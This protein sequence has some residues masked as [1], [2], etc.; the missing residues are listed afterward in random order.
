MKRSKIII[1]GS[2]IFA[3]VAVSIFSVSHAAQKQPPPTAA[4]SQATGK[5]SQAAPALPDLIVEGVWLDKEGFINFQLKNAGQAEIPDAQHRQ[6]MVRVTYGKEHKDFS[7]RKTLKKRPPVDPTGLLKKPGEVVQY[8]TQIRVKERL[9]VTVM[10][11][12]TKRI[13]EANEQN[14]QD[15]S[16]GLT[17]KTAKEMKPAPPPEVRREITQGEGLRPL[18]DEG[19]GRG[20]EEPDLAIIA[21]HIRTYTGAYS[22]TA[23]Y[24][25]NG[26][27]DHE[28]IIFRVF[29]K[30]NGPVMFT[31]FISVV[32][33][34]GS[35]RVTGNKYVT[36]EPAGP[37]SS[38]EVL[39]TLNQPTMIEHE[40]LSPGTYQFK[41]KF[42][43]SMPSDPVWENNYSPNEVTL[44]LRSLPVGSAIPVETITLPSHG[45]LTGSVSNRGN[46]TNSFIQVGN[47]GTGTARGFISF[48][49]SAIQRE[50]LRRGRRWTEFEITS[51]TLEIE[52]YQILAF[53]PHEGGDDGWG[54]YHA[55]SP[56]EPMSCS[57]GIPSWHHRAVGDILLDYLEGYDA[58]TSGIFNASMVTNLLAFPSSC[59]VH[60]FPN[61]DAY[62]RFQFERGERRIQFRL[63]LAGTGVVT[64]PDWTLVHSVFFRNPRLVV[65]VSPAE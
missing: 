22:D 49:L 63:R 5:P 8:N 1:I 51:A 62:V 34:S 9:T 40:G 14:N 21:F 27:G 3:L 50:L 59:G 16:L 47:F 15:V 18:E 2:I 32:V 36:L 4:P 26:S 53:N 55:G 25:Y 24:T 6:G 37:L 60:S 7:F 10:V 33:F 65:R 29:V 56:P 12:S 20:A 48:D 30:N 31:G 52:E 23:S 38:E 13:A 28:N 43:R 61:F 42:A 35:L 54:L 44:K 19:P 57:G 17:A 41:A 11:D 58:L 64:G 39:V 46:T 45:S